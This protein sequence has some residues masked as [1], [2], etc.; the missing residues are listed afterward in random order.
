M[1][2]DGKWQPNSNLDL[3]LQ[4]DIDVPVKLV[5]EAWTQPEHLKEWFVPRPWSLKECELDL[6]STPPASPR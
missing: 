1:T 5:W 4:R 2:N 6:R 3:V